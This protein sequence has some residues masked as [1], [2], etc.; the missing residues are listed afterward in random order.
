MRLANILMPLQYL[1]SFTKN[2]GVVAFLFTVSACAQNPATSATPSIDTKAVLQ[3]YLGKWR[4]TSFREEMNIVSL[5]ITENTFSF[6]MDGPSVRFVVDRKIDEGVIVRVTDRKPSNAF[7][8]LT[9]L[10]FLTETQTLESFP[11]GGP[12]KIR[13]LLRVCYWSGSIDQLVSGNKKALCG[14]TYIR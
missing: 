11:P 14:N 5:T 1:R 13:E 4:P 7:P 3:P 2:F 6:E 10:A 8:G 9:A 12:S